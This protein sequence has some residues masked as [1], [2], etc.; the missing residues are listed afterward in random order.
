MSWFT[1]WWLSMRLSYWCILSPSVS[2]FS[3][4]VSPFHLFVTT[5]AVYRVGGKGD[6]N[7]FGQNRLAHPRLPWYKSLRRRGLWGDKFPK[8]VS[9]YSAPGARWWWWWCVVCCAFSHHQKSMQWHWGWRNI[10]TPHVGK[11]AS[12]P[13]ALKVFEP[14]LNF[15]FSC[16]PFKTWPHKHNVLPCR[17]KVQSILWLWNS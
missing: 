17:P 3:L 16:F 12:K 4:E 10:G 9:H 14:F 5:V 7:L 11:S 8:S 1:E 6:R 2:G 13:F 15:S